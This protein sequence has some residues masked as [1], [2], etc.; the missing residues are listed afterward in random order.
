MNRSQMLSLLAVAAVAAAAVGCSKNDKVL[1][2]TITYT[3]VDR[4]A[5]PA[6]NTALIPTAMKDAFNRGK[7][8]TDI[9]TFRPTAQATI[10]ALRAAV[11]DS[12][13]PEDSPGLSAA[14]VATVLIPDIV[15]ID[16]SQPVQFPNGRR[17]SD[18]VID[19]A[20][21]LVLNRGDVLHGGP[22]VSDAIS[23][24]DVAFSGTFPYLAT[25]H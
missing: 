5:I 6:I 17:L 22:G 4:M 20:L 23:A 3:Q 9:A 8:S 10:V 7:P 2:P 16:F 1:V 25:P 21:S 13:P 11:A 15:T 24:N 19:A 12:L 14:T 18:D